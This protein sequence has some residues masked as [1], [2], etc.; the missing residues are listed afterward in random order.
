MS[1]FSFADKLRT[2]LRLEE[3]MTEDEIRQSLLATAD[4]PPK[5][6]DALQ[7][8]NCYGVS[9]L[10]KI[11]KVAK[12]VAPD[13]RKA[14]AESN[15]KIARPAWMSETPTQRQLDYLAQHGI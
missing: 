5:R 11:L 13:L 12:E 15:P 9:Q 3:S 10:S 1:M 7:L 14:R 4:D 8:A 6:S 2:R